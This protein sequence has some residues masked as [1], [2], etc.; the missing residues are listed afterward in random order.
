MKGGINFMTTKSMYKCN[1]FQNVNTMTSNQRK[2]HVSQMNYLEKEMTKT[3]LKKLDVN[4]LVISPHLFEKMEEKG[5]TFNVK[6][7]KN[8]IKNF[9]L[10]KNLVEVNYNADKSTRIALK[11]TKSIEVNVGGEVKECVLCFV[12]NLTNMHIVTAYYNTV[13]FSHR[14]PN[15][16][17]Y[18]SKLNVAK[19]L[20]PYIN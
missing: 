17:R 2:K 6:M 15:L 12:V 18:D 8:I 5:I 11:G 14:I 20:K 3:I 4:K 19:C 7:V 1:E 10:E 16:N 9:V 13:E